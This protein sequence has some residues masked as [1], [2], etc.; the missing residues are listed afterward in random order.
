MS[1]P[2]LKKRLLLPFVAICVTSLALLFLYALRSTIYAQYTA[3]PGVP[4]VYGHAINAVSVALCIA[5]V[6][7]FVRLAD[8]LIFTF[9]FRWRKGYE[10]PNLLR[11]VFSI[12][13]YTTLFAIIIRGFYPGIS[14]ELRHPSF[15][16][17]REDKN[18]KDV[19]IE[20]Q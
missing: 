12:V 5:L 7:I 8:E 6:F 14:A 17:L 16:G 13:A 10:A 4:V 20:N 3:V 9:A 1:R 15:K 19:V 18:A 2:S 11:N